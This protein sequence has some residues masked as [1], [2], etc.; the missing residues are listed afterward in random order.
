MPTASQRVRKVRWICALACESA[1]KMIK[2]M[3]YETAGTQR[4]DLMPRKRSMSLVLSPGEGHLDGFQPGLSR[5][6]LL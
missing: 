6:M 1:L 3:T 5:T 2:A 4:G